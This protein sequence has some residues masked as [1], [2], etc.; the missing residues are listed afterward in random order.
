MSNMCIPDIDYALS[1]SLHV[2]QSVG[3]PVGVVDLP[4]T[5][6]VQGVGYPCWGIRVDLEVVNIGDVI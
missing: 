4:Q 1:V 2:G 6:G 5:G 3:G